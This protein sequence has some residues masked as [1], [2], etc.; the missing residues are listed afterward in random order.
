MEGLLKGEN[1]EFSR[2]APAGSDWLRQALIFR[3]RKWGRGP[4]FTRAGGQ[5]D[6]SSIKKLPQ[7]IIVMIM[8]TTIIIIINSIIRFDVV[9]I[10]GHVFAVAD[11]VCSLL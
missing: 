10:G 1:P 2:L 8:I 7:L 4:P 3:R 9:F 5:D 11:G 6:V